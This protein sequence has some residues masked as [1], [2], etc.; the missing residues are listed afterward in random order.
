M[1]NL[2]D[3]PGGA[4]SLLKWFFAE[5]IVN[6]GYNAV[7]LDTGRVGTFKKSLKWGGNPFKSF[8]QIP[9]KTQ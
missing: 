5:H 2:A 6:N 1:G 7:Y 3:V 9:H 4:K 8:K